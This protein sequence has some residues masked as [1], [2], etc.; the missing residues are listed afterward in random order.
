VFAAVPR[1]QAIAITRVAVKKFEGLS[2]QSFYHRTPS[3]AQGSHERSKCSSLLSL[4][5]L[6]QGPCA[7]GFGSLLNNAI[8][9]DGPFYKSSKAPPEALA[10]ATTIGNRAGR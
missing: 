2:I 6:L 1:P 3:Q 10:L 9:A 8:V 4:A 5:Q 7:L